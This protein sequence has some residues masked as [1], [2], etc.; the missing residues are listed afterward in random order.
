MTTTVEFPHTTAALAKE[1]GV[2]RKTIRKWAGELGIGIDR[3]GRAGYLYSEPE[4]QKLIASRRPVT[5]PTPRRKK[6][7]A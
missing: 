7:A 5:A 2:T 1:F 4:R 6:K 3:A